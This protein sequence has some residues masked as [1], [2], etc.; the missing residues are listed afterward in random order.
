MYMR[1]TSTGTSMEWVSRDT[2]IRPTLNMHTAHVHTHTQC[3]PLTELHLA[4]AN[5]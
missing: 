4:F 3:E 1:G 5:T 2:W